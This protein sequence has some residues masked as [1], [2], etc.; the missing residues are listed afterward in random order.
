M[1]TVLIVCIAPQSAEQKSFQI[2]QNATPCFP[3]IPEAV[4][5]HINEFYHIRTNVTI[6]NKKQAPRLPPQKS[7]S[8]KSLYLN[9]KLHPVVCSIKYLRFF[10]FFGKCCSAPDLRRVLS[11][12]STFIDH[13]PGIMVLSPYSSVRPLL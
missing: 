5:G 2:I 13:S 9:V 11:L 8:E 6:N 3:V 7:L 1:F 4:F 12:N 10:H